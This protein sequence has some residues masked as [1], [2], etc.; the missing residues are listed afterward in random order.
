MQ[1]NPNWNDLALFAAVARAGGLTGAVAATGASAATLSRRMKA[2]ES[3]LSRR[4]FVHGRQGYVLT[5]DG[6]ALLEK[7]EKVEA[8]FVD[9]QAWQAQQAG[10]PRV[11]ISAGNWTA[12]LLSENILSFWSPSAQWVP[13]FVAN[14]L[15]LDIARREIDVGIRS[16]RPEQPWLAGQK[17][18]EVDF[19]TYGK[20]PD[21]T[22]WI[23]TSDTAA[24]GSTRWVELNH[25]ADIVTR[26]NDPY[27]AFSL[28]RSGVGRIVLPVFAGNF[29]GLQQLSEP[30]PELHREEWM[31]THHEGRYE[32]AV[33]A[34]LRSLA[35]FLKRPERRIWP[36]ESSGKKPQ[37]K[38]G[39]MT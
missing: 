28:A 19:A 17:T 8:A 10:P 24:V 29:S 35:L 23:G 25:G 14:V 27:L 15:P 31:V 13:E 22:G 39:K 21:V 38:D 33:R 11:R 34:A 30:I 18:A 9:V 3:S 36:K 37:A 26:V 2:L 16:R 6:R 7:A 4:L 20:S 5:S 1:S 32:P 12:L